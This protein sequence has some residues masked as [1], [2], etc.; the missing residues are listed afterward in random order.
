[1]TIER[2]TIVNQIEVGVDGGVGV[3]LELRLVE[4]DTVLSSK[5]HRTII[6][7][8][9]SPAEQLSY[10]NDHLTQMGEATITTGDIQRVGLFHKLAGDMPSPNAVELTVDETVAQIKEAQASTVVDPT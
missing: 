9:I 4:G 1:M 3:R 7:Q 6:P 8:D 2:K 10:V 5:W